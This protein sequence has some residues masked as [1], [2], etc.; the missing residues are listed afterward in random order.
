MLL[1]LGDNRLDFRQFP[2]LMAEWIGIGT[3]QGLATTPT[4]A[5][6]A[7]DDLSTLV[8]RNQGTFVFVVA[9]L[10]AAGALRFGL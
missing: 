9:W 4:F 7:R 6:H 8:R 3:S 1:I 10:A 5:R 2:D